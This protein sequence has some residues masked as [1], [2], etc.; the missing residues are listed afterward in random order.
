[1]EQVYIGSP[2]AGQYRITVTYKQ[3]FSVPSQD[4]SIIITGMQPTNPNDPMFCIDPD[5]FYPPGQGF[6]SFT[7]GLLVTNCGSG[8]NFTF[9]VEE[10]LSWV[11][12]NGIGLTTG[13]ITLIDVYIN[14]TGV[15][16]Q[17]SVHF[18]ADP[19]NGAPNKYLNVTQGL[20]T[21]LWLPYHGYIPPDNHCF[22]TDYAILAFNNQ[23]YEI[24]NQGNKPSLW[25]TAGNQITLKPGFIARPS[26]D[27]QFRAEIQEVILDDNDT[28]KFAGEYLSKP[29]I[30]ESYATVTGNKQEGELNKSQGTE[31]KV[32]IPASYGLNCTP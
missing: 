1:V 4:F 12:C 18:Y 14:L 20:A 11:D 17:G 2:T 31:A 21:Y 7:E 27:N 22:V 10:S 26:I 29:N 9:N 8:G 30:N 15:Y 13:L 25:V 24:S 28:L 5:P 32:E 3:L 23:P 16:R 19:P 6:S